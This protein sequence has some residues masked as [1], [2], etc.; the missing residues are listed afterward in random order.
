[1]AAAMLRVLT[2]ST[3]FP[4]ATQ[5]TLGVF[6]ERQTLG[7]AALDDVALEIVS[8]IGLPAWPLSLHPHYAARAR[9]PRREVW[10]GVTIH[11]PRFRTMPGIG[12]AR[13][14][15]AMAKA[16]LP[17]LRALRANFPFDVIDAEFFWPDG[18]AALCLSRALGVPFSIKARGAD[19]H[20][21][22]TRSGIGE[23]IIEAGRAADGLLAVSTALRSDMVAL[24]MPADRIRV[25]RTGVDLDRFQPID[26]AAAKARLGVEG[27]LLVTPGA[28]IPRKGQKLVLEALE[29]LEGATLLVV[30]EGPDRKAL[31]AIARSRNLSGRVRFLG[32]RPHEELPALLAAAD[33]MALSS[34]SEGLANV[35]VESLACGTPIVISDVGGAREVVDRPE[36]GRIVAREPEAIAA[37]IRE[38]VAYPP[39]PAAVRAAAER[40]S[41][42]RNARELREHL[43]SL[44]RPV[45]EAA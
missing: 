6:V 39:A 15:G 13:A 10:K 23:Q 31:E 22:S 27:P 35:W 11:R 26:R 20:Y 29:H 7:L 38:L 41:W 12:D 2:L 45:S 36:A 34:A 25:H 5:P 1:M 16:L 24:G 37:A 9:L 33:V 40:F 17:Q 18:P 4:Q 43:G 42:D 19:I 14:A 30:G 44:A 32:N 8:P 28:L 21:W 3:L